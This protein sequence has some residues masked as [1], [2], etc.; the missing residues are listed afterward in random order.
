MAGNFNFPLPAQETKNERFTSP[1]ILRRPISMYTLSQIRRR[2]DVL[3]HKYALE[4][5]I[6]KLRPLAESFSLYWSRQAAERQPL[7]ASQP[8]IRLIAR[9]GF[10]LNTFMA[11]HQYLE[12]CRRENAIPDA[13]GILSRLLPY[14][15]DARLLEMLRWP[16]HPASPSPDWCLRRARCACAAP[17]NIPGSLTPLPTPARRC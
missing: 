8:F 4:L 13:P 12:C 5:A 2:L 7:P 16:I 10:R 14:L 6:V 11:L 15:S 17:A 1:A 3:K 9:C